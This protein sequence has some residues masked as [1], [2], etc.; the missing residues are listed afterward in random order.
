[1]MREVGRARKL[2][3]NCRDVGFAKFSFSVD[4]N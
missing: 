1:M 3:G 2:R 4:I